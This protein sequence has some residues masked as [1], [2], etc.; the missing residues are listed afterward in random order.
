MG[1]SGT[2]VS[3]SSVAHAPACRKERQRPPSRDNQRTLGVVHYNS[4][5]TNRQSNKRRMLM[6]L[7]PYNQPPADI[8]AAQA[9]AQAPYPPAAF[10][11]PD[12]AIAMLGLTR[13]FGTKIAVNGLTLA[14]K[15]GEFF[16]FL[17]PNGAGKSTTI[18]MLVG[19]LR[20]SAG[21]AWVGGVDV[22]RDPIRAKLQMGVL[23]EQLNLYD[24]LSGRELIQFAGRL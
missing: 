3:A 17:G 10:P 24:R 9:A 2:S 16:G 21:R 19:L 23:P 4:C 11:P 7:P 8:A 22:W 20:P 13:T 15:R 18:K 12:A 6:S 14:V 5:D 1:A